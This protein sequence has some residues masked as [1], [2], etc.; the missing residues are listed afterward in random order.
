MLIQTK[1]HSLNKKQ[2][3]ELL[4]YKKEKHLNVYEH[5]E[6]LFHDVYCFIKI[7][8]YVTRKYFF[9]PLLKTVNWFS[10]R[11]SAERT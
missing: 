10:I 4:L 9:F 5:F 8:L 2:T 6:V 7:Y 11:S 1:I 3:N